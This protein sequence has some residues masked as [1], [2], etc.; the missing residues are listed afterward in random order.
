MNKVLSYLIVVAI[1][2]QAVNSFDVKDCFL[3][4]KYPGGIDCYAR[5]VRYHWNHW[6]QCCEE[7]IWD[8]CNDTP[9]NFY[10]YEECECVAGDFCRACYKP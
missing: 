7:V 6:S 9:N 1:M 2:F 8:G 5:L 4:F 10:S 3:P